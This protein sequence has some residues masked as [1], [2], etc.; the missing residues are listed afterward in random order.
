MR[1]YE[2]LFV[3]TNYYY[4]LHA[5]SLLNCN[6]QQMHKISNMF[7]KLSKYSKLTTRRPPTCYSMAL[8]EH[9]NFIKMYQQCA[10]FN[11]VLCLCTIK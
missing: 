8:L 5:F 3:S 7:S 10:N 11:I 2:N 9:H 6:F 4:F 1:R